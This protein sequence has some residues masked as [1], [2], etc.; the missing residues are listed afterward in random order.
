M[1]TLDDGRKAVQ[2]SRSILQ[3]YLNKIQIASPSL[4]PIFNTKLGVFVT[5]HTYPDQHLRGC[6]GIPTPILTLKKALTE[7]TQSVTHDPRFPP[8]RPKEIDKIIVEITV[9]TPPEKILIQNPKEYSNKITIGK[10]GLIAEQGFY[11][12]L[13]LPQVPIEQ[14]WDIVE[15]LSQTCMKAGLPA[16]AWLDTLTDIYRFSGQIFTEQI[17]KGTI[18]ERHIDGSNH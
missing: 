2:Y 6:V 3:Q 7:A 5:L 9:L 16:D 18:M 4:T 15:F 11:K 8:L 10:H 17:P 13:L 14:H 12:G 1:L